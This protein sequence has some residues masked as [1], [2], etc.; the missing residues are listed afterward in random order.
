MRQRQR[1]GRG[2]R[3]RVAPLLLQL[4]FVLLHLWRLPSLHPVHLPGG[5]DLL[6]G[7]ADA[8]PQAVRFVFLWV[9]LDLVVL[10]VFLSGSE[11]ERE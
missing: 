6:H 4:S 10:P 11:K 8:V 3:G 2:Q 1:Q 7:G 9:S 5:R